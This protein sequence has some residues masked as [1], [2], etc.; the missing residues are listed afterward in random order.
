MFPPNSASLTTH[1]FS[2]STYDDSAA[3]NAR[4]QATQKDTKT[5]FSTSAL[6]AAAL[7]AASFSAS[8]SPSSASSIGNT[9]LA[10]VQAASA[11]A[12]AAA[13]RKNHSSS[14]TKA[15][16]VAPMVVVDT[17][18][19]RDL[20]CKHFHS[21]T[22]TFQSK[23]SSRQSGVNLT[24][25]SFTFD[26]DTNLSPTPVNSHHAMHGIP[27]DADV[28]QKVA[29]AILLFTSTMERI[30]KSSEYREALQ[31]APPARVWTPA[32][33]A[34]SVLSAVKPSDATASLSTEVEAL[35]SS[36]LGAARI[37]DRLLEISCKNL[38]QIH[39]KLMI[40]W[41]R[42]HHAPYRRLKLDIVKKDDVDYP[43]HFE[44]KPSTKV[45]YVENIL[46]LRKI[47]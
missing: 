13:S 2:Y 1:T 8:S 29:D 37:T 42:L 27:D 23:T 19:Q 36:D 34:V 10:L 6:G 45:Q 3:Q 25:F 20:K 12:S 9:P 33:K 43:P 41:F 17:Q 18:E 46:F 14:V 16:V 39:Q 30:M 11:A 28:K 4:V 21:K 15:S 35:L 38:K 26:A 24:A 44:R 7:A 40:D 31:K 5:S 47:E 32:T 22:G